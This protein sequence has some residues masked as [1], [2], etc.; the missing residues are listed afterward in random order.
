MGKVNPKSHSH[1]ISTPTAIN[2]LNIANMTPNQGSVMGVPKHIMS[3]SMAIEQQIL[4]NSQRISDAS[5]PLK[6]GLGSEAPIFNT[7]GN[8]NNRI[9]EGPHIY[10][11]S[12]LKTN[13]NSKANTK[14]NSITSNNVNH[15]SSQRSSA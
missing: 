12:E 7:T 15:E 5:A 1:G 6:M 9:S 4:L 10:G 3:N 8:T 2:Q 11:A 13:T 14:R